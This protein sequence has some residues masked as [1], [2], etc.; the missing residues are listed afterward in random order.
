MKRFEDKVII[1]TGAAAGIGKA[2]AERIASEGGRVVCTDIQMEAVT[3]TA[4]EIRDAGGE[5]LAL[6]CDVSDPND[7][8]KAIQATIS[9]YGKI[10]SLCNI[11][12]ILHFDNTLDLELEKWNRIL[13]VNLTGTFLMCQA[14]LPHLLDGGG[15]IVNMASTAGLAGHPWTAA[16]SASKGGVLAL[17]STLAVEYGKKGVRANSVC[18]GSV[19]T[20]MHDQFVLPEGADVKLL[21]RIMPLDTFR[22]P[23]AAAALVAFLASEDAAHIN[24]EKIRVDGGTLA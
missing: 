23:E 20:A 13:K 15:S 19:K 11:A 24:G 17:T 3:A 7:V 16:Y 18:P 12:G 2:S 4:K 6:S 5:A 21:E 1:V 9:E 8:A 10:D 14:A 22:G